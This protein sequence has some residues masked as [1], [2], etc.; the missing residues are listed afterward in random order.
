MKEFLSPW[1]P[2]LYVDSVYWTA[3]GFVGNLLFSSRFVVQWLNSEKAG[4]VV[5][6]MI[7]W[8]I[9]FS[10]SIIMV[11]YALHIDKLPIILG[12]IFLPIIYG[13]NLILLR[14]NK[15]VT[16]GASDNKASA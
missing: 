10:A 4:K 3:L 16:K 13:R 15:D 8:R 6:P 1:F 2:W 5:V 14:R 12:N 7:F 9:S 11:L